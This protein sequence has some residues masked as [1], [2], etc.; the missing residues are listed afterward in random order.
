[1]YR[2]FIHSITDFKLDCIFSESMICQILIL[3]N[4]FGTCLFWPKRWPVFIC[5]VCALKEHTFQTTTPESTYQA[6][7]AHG[8]SDDYLM[9][10]NIQGNFFLSI[11]NSSSRRMFPHCPRL[12]PRSFL[13]H[14]YLLWRW[15]PLGTGFMCILS[16]VSWIPQSIIRPAQGHCGVTDSPEGKQAPVLTDLL[17]FSLSLYFDVCRLFVT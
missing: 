15:D 13:I 6:T 2:I 10:M 3:W 17:G 7:S 8:G 5:T 11:Q 14:P 1:M 12:C 4:F 16:P 9:V